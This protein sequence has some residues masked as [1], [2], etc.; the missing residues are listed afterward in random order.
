MKTFKE[1]PDEALINKEVYDNSLFG[2]ELHFGEEE[3]A[4][5]EAVKAADKTL[6]DFIEG[7][8]ELEKVDKNGLKPCP[9]CGGK[10]II[11]RYGG[12]KTSTLYCCLDCACSLET[13]ETF[14][15]GNRWNTRA[16]NT[17]KVVE[18]L[19]GE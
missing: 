8:D 11:E 9:F 14:N 12:K 2:Y 15:H 16:D 3:H 17:A 10:A 13:G 4:A 7:R 18:K 5:F 6:R 1:T 19:K